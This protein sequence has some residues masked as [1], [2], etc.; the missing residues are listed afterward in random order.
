MYQRLVQIYHH[1]YLV[2]VLVADGGQQTSRRARQ[3][4]RWLLAVDILL[5]R[6]Q[7]AAWPL[8]R[9]A[10]AKVRPQKAHF[11]ALLVVLG[12]PLCGA[13]AVGRRLIFSSRKC[14]WK[15]KKDAVN[16][17]GKSSMYLWK[18][19]YNFDMLLKY[20]KRIQHKYIITIE[21]LH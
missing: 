4:R 14:V 18:K 16:I 17:V 19:Y 7:L 21:S 10:A 13:P 8:P 3:A 1:A 20:W 9:Q 11:A 15:R 5:G 6:L 2:H 12:L